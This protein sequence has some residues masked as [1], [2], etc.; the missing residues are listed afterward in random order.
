MFHQMFWWQIRGES[1]TRV[2]QTEGLWDST[3][4]SP[5]NIWVT[6]LHFCLFFPNQRK[7]IT[8]KQGMQKQRSV[9][10][11]RQKYLQK[12]SN[13]KQKHCGKM[14]FFLIILWCIVTVSYFLIQINPK[15]KQ[16][17]QTFKITLWWSTKRWVGSTSGGKRRTDSPK[18]A[19]RVCW[20]C[21]VKLPHPR[22]L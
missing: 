13:G 15:N 2:R 19:V 17:S 6:E 9:E 11:L 4:S 12:R 10:T 7:E 3:F 20:E 8:L 5:Q 21:L 18:H 22:E 1:L 14:F 16:T